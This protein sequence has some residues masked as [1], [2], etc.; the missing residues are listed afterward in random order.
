MWEADFF[1]PHDTGMYIPNAR[2]VKK[3]FQWRV[4]Y[5]TGIINHASQIVLEAR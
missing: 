5:I 1:D 2:V 4:S 3:K